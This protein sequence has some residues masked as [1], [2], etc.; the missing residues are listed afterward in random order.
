M[1]EE[2][3]IGTWTLEVINDGR[4]LVELK[5]WHLVFLGTNEHPQ[6]SLKK[7]NTQ[8]VF[9]QPSASM[10][11]PNPMPTSNINQVDPNAALKSQVPS[12]PIQDVTQQKSSG[13]MNAK[14]E[15]IAI[16]VSTGIVV[17]ALLFIILIL[18]RTWARKKLYR[19][20]H[21]IVEDEEAFIP[22]AIPYDREIPI[23]LSEVEGRI[24]SGSIHE[25]KM[26]FTQF[27][28]LDIHCYKL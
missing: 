5:A 28:F 4:S 21:R 17:S 11:N 13:P 24:D 9:Q 27:I 20:A 25:G 14:K 6:P 2:S 8:T 19:A 3:P 10:A 12:Q 18:S 7:G 23:T 15:V 26:Q 22:Y 16:S 1:W